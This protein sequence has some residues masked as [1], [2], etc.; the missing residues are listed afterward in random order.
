MSGV[1]LAGASRGPPSSERRKGS[2]GLPLAAVPV[3]LAARG[4]DGSRPLG[5]GSRTGAGDRSRPGNGKG[6]KVRRG[7]CLSSTKLRESRGRS[8]A[9]RRPSLPRSG[10]SSRGIEP[11]AL[12]SRSGRSRTEAF[13]SAGHPV[14]CL[15]SKIVAREK[16]SICHAVRPRTGRVGATA[17]RTGLRPL[18]VSRGTSRILGKRGARRPG[19]WGR[20]RIRR[21]GRNVPR[22]ARS[23][24]SIS[25][26]VIVG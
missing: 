13:G 17:H 10:A 3:H 1:V 20:G 19:R 9:S 16:P 22:C 24:L 18:E 7:R 2:R 23:I 12:V 5:P 21:L 8:T 4:K 26:A 15:L 14:S 11:P 6:T 25:R